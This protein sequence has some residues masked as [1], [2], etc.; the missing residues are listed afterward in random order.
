MRLTGRYCAAG[1][2]RGP[3]SLLRR[4]GM[5]VAFAL[6]AFVM[7]M[8]FPL[9]FALLLALLP[10]FF[11]AIFFALILAPFLFLSSVPFSVLVLG[12]GGSRFLLWSTVEFVIYILCRQ[13]QFLGR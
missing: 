11:F 5:T 3:A 2:C 9:V 7:L 1:G 13:D 10:N 12:L 8:M 6:R 4:A